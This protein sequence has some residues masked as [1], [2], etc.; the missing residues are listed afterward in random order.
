MRKRIRVHEYPL[1]NGIRPS[2]EFAKKGLAEFAVNTGTKCGHGCTYCSTGAMLRCH[3]SFKAAGESPFQHG[4]AIV[5]PEM[6]EKVAHDAARMQRRGQVQLCTTVDAWA[7]EA[8]KYHLGR[9]CL[10]A[11]LAEPGWTVRILTKNAAVVEDFDL[12]KKHRDRVVVGLSLTGTPKADAVLKVIEPNASSIHDRMAA[13]AKA[14]EMGLRTYG[15]LCPL[16]PGIADSPDDLDTLVG[17]AESI[18]AEE[19]FAEA[20]NPRGRGLKL[21]EEALA[22]AGFAAQAEAVHGIRSVRTWSPYVT[23]L[24]A[25]V[26]RACQQ[27]RMLDKLRFLLYPAR[28]LPAD[29]TAIQQHNAGVVWL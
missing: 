6:P 8:Q 25:N 26:Q 27:H 15:M 5:D 11:I 20:V 3:K 17:F 24:V 22:A 13:L 14:H 23:Q 28:L 18:A 29:R 10:E 9:R 2:P 12:I 19:L 1:K 16:L 4:Y 21:T 7:P